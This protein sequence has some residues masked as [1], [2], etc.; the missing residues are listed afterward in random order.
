MGAEGV[1]PVD[2]LTISTIKGEYYMGVNVIWMKSII[3]IKNSPDMVP[4][5]KY[6]YSHFIGRA[7]GHPIAS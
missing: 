3:K 2:T 7:F 4:S 5:W 6:Q 1:N